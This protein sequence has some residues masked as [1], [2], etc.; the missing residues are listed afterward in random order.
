MPRKT[1]KKNRAERIAYRNAKPKSRFQKSKRFMAFTL[2]LATLISACAALKTTKDTEKTEVAQQEQTSPD[3][4]KSPIEPLLQK[5][6]RET[7]K[8]TYDERGYKTHE[9]DQRQA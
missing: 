8:Y 3:Y 7:S 9:K 1:K 5:I 4:N 6:A 2:G